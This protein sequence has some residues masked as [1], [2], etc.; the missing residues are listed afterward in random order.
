LNCSRFCI[1][2]Y[3][4]ILDRH[5]RNGRVAVPHTAESPANLCW[6]RR[7][8]SLHRG[9]PASHT[10]HNKPADAPCPE[11]PGQ[12]LQPPFY[13]IFSRCCVTALLE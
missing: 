8:D 1:Y 9:N 11:A 6:W 13:G 3:Q 12:I 2:Q 10:E 5:S 7:Q 4:S